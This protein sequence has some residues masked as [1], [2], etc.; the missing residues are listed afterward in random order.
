M[1]VCLMSVSF[2]TSDSPTLPTMGPGAKDMM[3]GSNYACTVATWPS[4]HNSLARFVMFR[5]LPPGGFV[6]VQFT[7]KAKTT[8]CN[9]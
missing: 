4:K 7:G 3:D 2:K 5:P 6:L 1:F 8:T 9:S